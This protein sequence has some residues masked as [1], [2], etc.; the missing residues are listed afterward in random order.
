MDK[1]EIT[2]FGGTGF[3][4]SAIV[5]DLIDQ[6]YHVRIACRHPDKAGFPASDNLEKMACDIQDDDSVKQAVR[7]AR[8]VVNAVSLYYEKP[9]LTFDAVHVKGAGRAA[10]LAKEAGVTHFV[11][12]SGI[13]ASVDSASAYVRARARGEQVVRAE[14][15]EATILRPSVISDRN[16][17]FADNLN[18]VTKLPVVPLFG[19]GET[20]LQPVYVGDVAAAVR[21]AIEMP[22][23][24]GR[25]LELGGDRIY[26]YRE[27]LRMIMQREGRRRPMVP[28]PFLCWRML[29]AILGRLPRPPLTRDQVILMEAD[30]VVGSQVGRFADLGIQPLSLEEI[31][32]L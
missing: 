8:S 10:R 9:G 20:R 21:R 32:R 18:R 17:G 14:F 5:R 12:I 29:A 3:L 6:G 28:V 4:G 1:A 22:E 24:G 16:D 19:R 11:Q 30:N 7:G 2:V 27:C 13:G 25:D 23:G 31:L 26:S 15:E